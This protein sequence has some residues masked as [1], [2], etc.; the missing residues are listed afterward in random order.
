MKTYVR[1][2]QWVAELSLEWDI[3]DEVLKKIKTHI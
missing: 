1:V 2:W 3:F